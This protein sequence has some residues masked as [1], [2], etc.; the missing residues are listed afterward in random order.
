[1]AGTAGRVE[2]LGRIGAQ[3]GP[4]GSRTGVVYTRAACRSD[5]RPRPIPGGMMEG[6]PMR[7]LVLALAAVLVLPPAAGAQQAWVKAYEDGVKEFER[8]ND[9]LAEAKL[10]EAR[11]RGRSCS[12]GATTTTRWS[13]GRSSPTSTWA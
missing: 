11:E 12:R 2:A 10:I 8:G 3:E 4:A 5:R 1:M 13:T 7:A 9:A 6:F